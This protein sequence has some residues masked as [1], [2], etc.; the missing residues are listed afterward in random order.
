MAT[1]KYTAVSKDGK[2]VSGVMEGFNE[3]TPSPRSRSCTPSCSR[4]AK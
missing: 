3:L 4:S 2:K 1:F